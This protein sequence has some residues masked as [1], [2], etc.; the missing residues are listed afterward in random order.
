MKPSHGYMDTFLPTW[1][2]YLE[3]PSELLVY[4]GICILNMP[5][6]ESHTLAL[7]YLEG[8]FDQIH[9]RSTHLSYT[10]ASTYL[11]S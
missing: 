11:L 1:I 8:R 2:R 5:E 6:D 9:W 3:L 4:F 10:G 7:S